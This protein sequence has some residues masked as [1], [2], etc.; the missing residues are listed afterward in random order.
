MFLLVSLEFSP[1]PSLVR[2]VLVRWAP[3]NHS[4][5]NLGSRWGSAAQKLRSSAAQ[6]LRSSEAQQPSS[7][8]AQQPGRH[9]RSSGM[10][11]RPLHGAGKARGIHMCVSLHCL[12]VL[13][14]S[15]LLCGA[16]PVLVSANLRAKSKKQSKQ[17]KEEAGS[18][19][20]E[21]NKASKASLDIC[22]SRCWL[23][24]ALWAGAV[25]LALGRLPWV[26]FQG[27]I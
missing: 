19:K 25:G 7:P 16:L 4:I 9:N 14:F 8:A 11:S 20:Q 22:F 5:R 27:R 1:E 23:I 21:A 15:L 26:H 17:S 18:K 3:G 2:L 13:C 24:S 10:N 12:L 6:Q